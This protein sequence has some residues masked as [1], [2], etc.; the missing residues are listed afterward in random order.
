MKTFQFAAVFLLAVA[1]ISCS[2]EDDK[3]YELPA[4]AVSS[5][6]VTADGFN[7]KQFYQESESE[8][9]RKGIVI[10]AHGDGGDTN[11]FNLNDQCTALAQQGYVAVTT[12]YR[13]ITGTIENQNSM[14]KADMEVVIAQV[15]NDFE[16]PR[17]KV[18]IGGM[19][20]GGNS[21]FALVLPNQLGITPIAGIKGV[22]LECSGGDEWKGSAI[23]YPVAYMSNKNDDVMQVPDTNVFKNG[24]QN[25]NN[26]GVS[27]LSGCLI[28]DSTGHCS[29]AGFYKLFVV[30]KVK[31][32]LP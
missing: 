18:I 10:L 29:D 3:T 2:K 30:Q 13:P 6:I 4:P 7:Y 9:T 12:S 21:T 11:D 16:I 15:T 5:E 23:L 14:F 20:R 31:E 8:S 24:L 28:I 22:I 19:S 17:G 1:A 26:P 27:G 32:W 25:N